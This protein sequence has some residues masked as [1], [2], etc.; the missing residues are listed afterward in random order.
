MPLEGE[1]APGTSA[2]ARE[3]AEAYE[4][5]NGERAATI[6][7]RPVVVVT[8]L[9]ARTGNLRKT[10]LMRV[11]HEGR[12]AVV[13]SD[14]ARPRNPA[15]YHNL[16]ANPRVEVRDGAVAQ[17]M[18]ARELTGDEYEQWWVRAV[19]AFPTYASYRKKAPRHIPVFLLEP[20]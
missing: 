9:G 12:Y 11:E 7:G 19:A 13:A 20:A 3:Q 17:D 6:G 5:S 2:W 15:W 8:S 10:A 4:E 18:V 16:V 1:Y 14:G